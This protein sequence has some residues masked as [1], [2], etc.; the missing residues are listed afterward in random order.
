MPPTRIGVALGLD[1]AGGRVMPGV[2]PPR[3]TRLKCDEKRNG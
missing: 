1:L 2:G 3:R